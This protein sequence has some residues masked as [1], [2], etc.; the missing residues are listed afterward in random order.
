VSSD[1]TLRLSPRATLYFLVR[2]S[3]VWVVMAVWLAS[4][5]GGIFTPGHAAPGAALW[6]L[7]LCVGTLFAIS[8]LLCYL[9][10][11]SYAIE[12]GPEGVALEYGVLRTVHETL[13]YGRIQDIL[14][15]RSVLER[16]LGLATLTLQNASGTPGVIPALDAGDANELRAE[17]LKRAAR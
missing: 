7:V 14:I 16:L 10:A 6:P 2:R 1:G 15:T 9:R 17:I 13:M 12:L 5:F 3:L 8:A 11:R 4:M